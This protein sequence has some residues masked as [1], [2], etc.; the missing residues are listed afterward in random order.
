MQESRRKKARMRNLFMFGGLGLAAAVVLVLIILGTR[1]SAASGELMGEEIPIPST[2]HV[3]AT[4]DPGPYPSNPPAGGPHFAEDFKAGFFDEADLATLPPYPEGYLVHNLEHGY[5]IFWY[6]CAAVPGLDC[7]GLKASI[8]R[9]MDQFNG[10]KLIAF[11]WASLDTPLA[12]TSWG[13]L[14]KMA[15]TDEKVMADFVRRNRY[16]APE[17]NAP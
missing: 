6:N 7:E 15:E 14:L 5:V 2:Q 13:R 1:N 12:L 8:R 11:P 4:R 10:V 16:K 3:D 17:P 9:V